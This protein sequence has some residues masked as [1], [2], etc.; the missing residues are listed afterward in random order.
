[1]TSRKPPSGVQSAIAAVDRE[2]YLARRTR[3][4]LRVRVTTIRGSSFTVN[5]SQGG[6]CTEQLRVLPVGS[7]IDGLI[8]LDGRDAIFSGRVTWTLFGDPRLNQ[9]GR[10]GVK[11]ERIGPELAQGMAA[12]AARAAPVAAAA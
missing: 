3:H 2:V 12:R 4:R 6:V 8:S 1:M 11:F 9:L 10:M 5:V 7:R